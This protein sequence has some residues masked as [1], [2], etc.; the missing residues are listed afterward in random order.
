MISRSI[1]KVPEDNKELRK[2]LRKILREHYQDIK[3]LFEQTTDYDLFEKRQRDNE[4]S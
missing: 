2:F 3:T 1:E 4:G